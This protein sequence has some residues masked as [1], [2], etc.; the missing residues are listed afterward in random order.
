MAEIKTVDINACM[1]PF[2]DNGLLL[3]ITDFCIQKNVYEKRKML[4]QKLKLLSCTMMNSSARSVYKELYN[5]E[6][7]P[8][9]KI[10]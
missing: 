10:G 1:W 3:K 2:F 6:T 8:A 7:Y 9:C 5:H 4:E